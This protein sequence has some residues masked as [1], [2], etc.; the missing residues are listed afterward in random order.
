M[1]SESNDDHQNNKLQQN[2]Y[3]SYLDDNESLTGSLNAT[4]QGSTQSGSTNDDFQKS[5]KRSD[6]DQ[7]YEKMMENRR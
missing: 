1:I 6:M 3:M 2:D 7:A 4:G 5:A